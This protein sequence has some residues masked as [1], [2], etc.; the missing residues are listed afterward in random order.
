MTSKVFSQQSTLVPE[1][2]SRTHVLVSVSQGWVIFA[3]CIQLDCEQ[4]NRKRKRVAM[5]NPKRSQA[6]SE[7]NIKER[8]RGMAKIYYRDG[9]MLL[10]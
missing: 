5:R 6:A 7:R 8:R 4:R 1:I 2:Q 9:L 10:D 3:I